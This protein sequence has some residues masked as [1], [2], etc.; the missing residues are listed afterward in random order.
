VAKQIIKTGRPTKSP[1][2]RHHTSIAKSVVNHM[3]LRTILTAFMAFAL[4]GC[5]Y[6]SYAAECDKLAL[7]YKN[8]ILQC[9]GSEDYGFY[10]T[11]YTV[12]AKNQ[13][14]GRVKITHLQHKDKGIYS[15]PG[16]PRRESILSFMFSKNSGLELIPESVV[17]EHYSESNQLLK[18][19]KVRSTLSKCTG[20]TG[21][22]GELTLDYGHGLP[23]RLIEKVSFTIIVDGEEKVI[24]YTIPIEYKFHYSEF[25][26]LMS[27]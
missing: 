2:P 20:V 5:R 11:L 18:P 8:H 26:V 21:C 3:K 16:P 23:K 7:P 27:V 25:D 9:D 19:K 15:P 22:D 10:S 1:A 12:S 6:Y 13:Y 14:G 17:L 24:S 4:A